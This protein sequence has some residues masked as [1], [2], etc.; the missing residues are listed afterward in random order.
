MK[1]AAIPP[2]PSKRNAFRR[3]SEKGNSKEGRK[4]D[5]FPLPPLPSSQICLERVFEPRGR[6]PCLFFSSSPIP[7]S[8]SGGTHAQNGIDKTFAYSQSGARRGCVTRDR[9]A[10]RRGEP[11]D[12][13][14]QKVLVCTAAESGV[15]RVFNL[16]MDRSR[17][18]LYEAS[19]RDRELAKA[20]GTRWRRRRWLW[21]AEERGEV[22]EGGFSNGGRRGGGDCECVAV[23]GALSPRRYPS[24]FLFFLFPSFFFHLYRKNWPDPCLPSLSTFYAM[25]PPIYTPLKGT[26]WFNCSLPFHFRH[27][28]VRYFYRIL[29]VRACVCVIPSLSLPGDGIYRESIPFVLLRIKRCTLGNRSVWY[30][31]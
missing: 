23:S 10:Q 21:K 2:L 29:C 15:L 19:W 11:R 9:D 14:G 26:M 8:P 30:L 24:F 31:T 18:W 16:E 5:P 27:N 4:K 1:R 6:K 12:R 28:C 25:L 22:E 3:V 7:S 20:W 17:M 13:A